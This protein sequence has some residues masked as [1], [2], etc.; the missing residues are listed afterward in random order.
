MKIS[1]IM[2]AYN[3]EKN[4]GRAI[5][6]VREILDK[7]NYDYEIIIVDDGSK[8]RTKEI[9]YY[10]AKKD[11][12]IKVVSYPKNMGKG[13]ALKRGFKVS[14][15]DVIVFM[16][17]DMEI[18]PSLIPLYIEALRKADIAIG[19]KW[20]PKSEVNTILIRKFLSKAF[21]LLVRIL[22]G[23]K[24]T[25]TQVGL[26][27]FKR[28]VLEKLMKVQFVKRYTFD[29]ELLAIASYLGL[30]IIELPVAIN[31]KKAFRPKEIWNMFIEL[32]GIT[33]RLKV[34]KWYQKF[35]K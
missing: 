17:S 20:H 6:R 10:Y 30:R 12:R 31:L 1:L 2:P 22:V 25:D 34:S 18:E 33:Y 13:Y 19:S 16:D 23:I 28:D 21:N 29:V 14:T 32:I 7:C 11:S 26:K 3:E 27:A 35:L 9:A 8:D 24:V 5:M 4:I 15:G